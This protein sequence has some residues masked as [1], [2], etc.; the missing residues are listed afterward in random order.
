ME[1]IEAIE[2]KFLKFILE[3]NYDDREE[4]A[5][6]GK[7]KAYWFTLYPKDEICSWLTDLRH[8]S[9]KE[10]VVQAINQFLIWYEQNKQLWN[11]Q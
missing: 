10:A 11:T 8:K 6:Y 1:M 7:Y 4:F 2:T 3:W 5:E 9:R